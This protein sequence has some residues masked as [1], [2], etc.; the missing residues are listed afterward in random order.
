MNPIK[1][2]I[3]GV[4]ILF[5]SGC[6]KGN[7]NSPANYNEV[8]REMMLKS[9]YCTLITI[10][11]LGHPKGRLMDPM[12]P[13]EKFKVYLATNPKS[14]KVQEI[15]LNPKVSIFY[16]ISGN[17]GYVSLLGEAKILTDAKSKNTFWKES[18]APFYKDRSVDLV[19]IE[20]TCNKVEL[21]NFDKGIISSQPDWSAPSFIP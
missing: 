16:K 11:S 10:D 21:V 17:T 5:L 8:A 7:E 18:W 4:S 13:N 6:D 9:E 2:Y 12:P 15:I 1:A 20:F 3:I 14:A 19:L